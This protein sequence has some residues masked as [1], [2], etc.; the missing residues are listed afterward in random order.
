[1]SA[2]PA[3]RPAN[4]NFSSGPCAKRPGWTPDTLAEAV[5]RLRQGALSLSSISSSQA[6]DDEE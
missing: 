2:R 1:M 3:S 5:A 6:R 4:P